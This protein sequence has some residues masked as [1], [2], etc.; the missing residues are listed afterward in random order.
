M[1]YYFGGRKLQLLVT[2]LIAAYKVGVNGKVEYT[3]NYG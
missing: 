2:A 3:D 1:N